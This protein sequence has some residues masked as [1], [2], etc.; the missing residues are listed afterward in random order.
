MNGFWKY[1]YPLIVWK[2]FIQIKYKENMTCYTNL[3][4]NV[5]KYPGEC[6][7][8]DL[9]WPIAAT[10]NQQNSRRNKEYCNKTKKLTTK[11]QNLAKTKTLGKR[12]KLSQNKETQG[13]TNREQYSSSK[14]NCNTFPRRKFHWWGV[15]GVRHTTDV[16]IYLFSCRRTDGSISLSL[17]VIIF[18]DEIPMAWIMLW[19]GKSCGSYKKYR[20]DIFIFI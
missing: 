17:S 7:N 16:M 13:K 10:T 6:E 4:S 20:C 8:W 14:Q 18:P 5:F 19:P 9:R 11:Q 2:I 3:Q 15:A 1:G 12:K